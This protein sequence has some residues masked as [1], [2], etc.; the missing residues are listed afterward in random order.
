MNTAWQTQANTNLASE[1][2]SCHSQ[3][4][5]EFFDQWGTDSDL[6]ELD[7]AGLVPFIG[8]CFSTETRNMEHST[9]EQEGSY[10]NSFILQLIQPSGTFR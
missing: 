5:F 1:F 9:V 4:D 2:G 6:G 7:W 3:W 10:G 8:N